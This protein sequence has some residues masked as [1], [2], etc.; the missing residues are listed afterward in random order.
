MIHESL[1]VGTRQE[2]SMN[3]ASTYESYTLTLTYSACLD[4]SIMLASLILSC[5]GPRLVF[6]TIAF[7]VDLLTLLNRR[8][9]TELTTMLETMIVDGTLS[10]AMNPSEAQNESTLGTLA[11]STTCSW[12]IR[13]LQMR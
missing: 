2:L 11:A 6:H 13:A 12:T 7:A 3:I 5:I 8:I 1:K 9:I 10:L 4:A